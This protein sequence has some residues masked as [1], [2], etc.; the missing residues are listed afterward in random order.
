VR[1]DPECVDANEMCFGWA[2]KGECFANPGYMMSVCRKSCDTACGAKPAQPA[3]V[4]L[5]EPWEIENL[6]APLPG[7]KVEDV[8]EAGL[9]QLAQEADRAGMPLVVW[10]YAPWCKQCKI[11]RPGFEGAAKHEL[12]ADRAIFARL[13]CVA[14]PNAK[15]TYGV[16]AYP[17]FKVMRGARHRWIDIGRERTA[18]TIS[19]A[20]ARELV[21][22]FRWL[23]TEEALR[24]AMYEQSAAGAAEMDRIGQGEAL[25]V[26]V[27]PSPIGTAAAGEAAGEAAGVLNGAAARYANMSAGCSAKLSPLPYVAVSD[28]ELLPSL[29]LPRVPYGHLALVQLYTEPSAAPEEAKQTPRLVSTPLLPPNAASDATGNDDAEE[30]ALCRWTLGNRLPLLVDFDADPTWGKRAGQLS[31]LTIHAL[32]F[33]SPPHAH[34]ASVVRSAAATFMRGRILVM[35]F[36]VDGIEVGNNAM[37]PRYGVNSVLDTPKLIFLDQRLRADENRQVPFKQ[38]IT[39]EAVVDFIKGRL[40]IEEAREVHAVAGGEAASAERKDEL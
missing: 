10:F 5:P 34:L 28:E 17:A 7:S 25:A 3:P 31:F 15:A 32:L 37:L 30:V 12:V 14:N 13:D 29:G 23:D 33:L 20:V 19:A 11:A 40:G 18:E 1:S 8:D 38:T 24:G 26:A 6:E 2:S 35:T 22:P 27:L 39:Y 21:G 16:S 36:M 4:N 9:L